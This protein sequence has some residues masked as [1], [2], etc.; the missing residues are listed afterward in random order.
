MVGGMEVSQAGQELAASRDAKTRRRTKP[1]ITS[2]RA[3]PDA[4][5]FPQLTTGPQLG[6][7]PK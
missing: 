6:E 3:S 1:N 4:A 2:H 5:H 7:S